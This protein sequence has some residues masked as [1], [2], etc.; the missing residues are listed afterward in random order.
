MQFTIFRKNVRN[1]LLNY[2]FI[3]DV[4]EI[5]FNHTV[6]LYELERKSTLRLVPKLTKDHIEIKMSKKISV[7][8]ATQ[9]LSESVEVVLKTYVHFKQMKSS[10]LPT[11]AFVKR[12]NKV[13]DI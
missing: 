4:S 5:W 10:A 6:K 9:V 1:N 13:F 8:L 11:A 3:I 12:I 2:N 7:R